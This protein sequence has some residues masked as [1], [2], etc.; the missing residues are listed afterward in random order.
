MVG[1]LL[2]HF[3]DG[4]DSGEILRLAL[5]LLLQ[6]LHLRD[7]LGRDIVNALHSSSL[8]SCARRMLAVTLLYSQQHSCQYNEH[9][10]E[11]TLVLA[12]R[13][14]MQALRVKIVRFDRYDRPDVGPAVSG[15]PILPSDDKVERGKKDSM[16][17]LPRC[18]DIMP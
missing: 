14:L 9:F 12:T 6:V 3:D 15:A 4:H 11:H 13:H 16:L 1:S 18:L 7:A 5:Q 2:H 8:T 10:H 17:S